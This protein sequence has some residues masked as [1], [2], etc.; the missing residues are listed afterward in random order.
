M[1]ERKYC[2]FFL[3]SISHRAWNFSEAQ[4]KWSKVLWS[5]IF[6]WQMSQHCFYS[7][8]V[9]TIL[10]Q[11]FWLWFGLKAHQLEN[12]CDISSTAAFK[13]AAVYSSD[14]MPLC[15]QSSLYILLLHGWAALMHRLRVPLCLNI[16]SEFVGGPCSLVCSSRLLRRHFK[17]ANFAYFAARV[18]P[19]NG[20]DFFTVSDMK[21]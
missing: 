11:T 5:L 20:H 8:L 10:I 12:L 3:K 17:K 14:L 16:Y 18:R 21:M 9:I 15:S 4:M 1:V 7:Y 6:S 19:W 13:Q 2:L